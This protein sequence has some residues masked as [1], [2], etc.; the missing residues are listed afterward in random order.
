MPNNFLSSGVYGCVYHPPYDCQGNPKSNKKYVSK[1]VKADFTSKTEYKVGEILKEYMS[2]KVNTKNSKDLEDLIIKSGFVTAIKSCNIERNYLTKSKM[3]PNCKL[4][5][6]DP[7][8]DKKYVVLYSQYVKSTEL[9]DYLKKNSTE[10]LIM[11]TYFLICE[12]I[13]V[14]SIAGI[15]HH[16]LH[17]GNILYDGNKL[18]VIDFGLA[19][20]RNK[21]LIDNKPNYL[22]LKEAIFKYSPSW[23]YWTLE[24]HF[25]CYL[26]HEGKLTRAIIEYTINYYLSKNGILKLLGSDFLKRYQQMALAYFM[27]YDE[28]PIDDAVVDLLE[29]SRTWDLYKIALHFLE[30]YY[31]TKIELPAFKTL[32]MIMLHPIPGYRPTQEEMKEFNGILINSQRFNNT[33]TP[34]HFSKELSK[35]LKRTILASKVYES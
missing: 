15:V 2:K 30:I 10:K 11:K 6:K 20:L 1:L 16:D 17:F 27:K 23:N 7:A 31:T 21:F 33:R 8:L 22:Y 5:K 4:L 35:N 13:N 32:L 34:G 26:V 3:V 29:T 25:L 24:Y 18:Y 14:M 19:M 28:M 9:S 12:R